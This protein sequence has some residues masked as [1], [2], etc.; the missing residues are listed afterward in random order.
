MA[1]FRAAKP[2]ALAVGVVGATAAALLV[3]T[4]FST[5]FSVTTLTA[6]CD[7][8]AGPELRDACVTTGGEQHSYALLLLGALTGVMTWGAA[9]G[10]SRP[11]GVALVVVGVV[12]VVI[13]LA[14]DLPDAGQTGEVGLNFTDAEASPGP[15]MY[16][17]LVAGVLALSAGVLALGQPKGL[18]PTAD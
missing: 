5:I 12:A 16:L 10:R 11:A 14:L 8:L 1:G 4:E 2:R 7:D 6:S 15:G 3:I 18:P 17:E 9:V 13:A